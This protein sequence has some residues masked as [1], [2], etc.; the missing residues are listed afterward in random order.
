MRMVCY[1]DAPY[2]I[3]E[4]CTTC[5]GEGEIVE[6]METIT[7]N[8][9]AL[10]QLL[11]AVAGPDH[12]IRELQYTRSLPN[13]PINVLLGEYNAIVAAHNTLHQE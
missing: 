9:A 11:V 3:T 6:P 2:E 1:G 5:G 12:H 8:F 7:V 4:V 13:N 10:K